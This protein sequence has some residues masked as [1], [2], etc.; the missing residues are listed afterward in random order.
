M[1]IA[2]AA[3]LTFAARASLIA[4]AQFG[5][6]SSPRDAANLAQTL[7][8]LLKKNQTLMKKNRHL[9]SKIAFLRNSS[10]EFPLLDQIHGLDHLT[11]KNQQLQG[12]SQKLVGEVAVVRNKLI[13]LSEARSEV[14]STATI[15]VWIVSRVRKALI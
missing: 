8:R 10:L 6:G 9:M 3:A 1:P 4:T 5:S 7:D 2:N 14:K 15:A 13:G 11:D 12:N